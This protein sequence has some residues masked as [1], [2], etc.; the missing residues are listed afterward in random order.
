[1]KQKVEQTLWLTIQA[2]HNS[3]QQEWVIKISRSFI[4]EIA[5]TICAVCPIL[6]F[7]NI[8]NNEITHFLARY[9]G[10]LKGGV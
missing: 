9:K 4:S 7:K 8:A 2:K 3:V 5:G 6:I 10:T 1:M